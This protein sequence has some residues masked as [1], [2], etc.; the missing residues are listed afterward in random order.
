MAGSAA[1]SSLRCKRVLLAEDDEDGRKV[2]AQVLTA[3]GL[4]VITT[5]DG[6]RMLVAIASHY[7]DG[8]T[9][10]DVDLIITDVCMP[11]VSGLELFKGLRAAGWTTPVIVVTAHVTSDVQHAVARL[12]AVLLSKPLE[13]GRFEDAV[14]LALAR[15]RTTA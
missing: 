7:K 2:M 12:D 10:D 14:Q 9:P 15:P 4:D 6:G 5:E 1:Q 3:M 11:V 13:L 8:R